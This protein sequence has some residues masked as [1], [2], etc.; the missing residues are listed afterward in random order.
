MIACIWATT[1]NDELIWGERN[2][3]PSVYIHRIATNPDFRGRNL[4]KAI[5]NWADDYSRGLNLKFVRMDTVGY[6][7]GLINHYQKMGF[8][9]VGT[10]TLEVTAGLPDHYKEGEV[11]L[12]EREVTPKMS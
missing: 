1:L 4:V 8:A 10:T 6:N 2:S 9:S 11:Y 3:D 7:P 12:F 5:V